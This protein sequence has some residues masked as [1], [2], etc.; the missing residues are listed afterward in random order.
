MLSTPSKYRKIQ[1][2]NAVNVVVDGKSLFIKSNWEQKNV[3]NNDVH[4]NNLT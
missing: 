1:K 2:C 3:D 4:P